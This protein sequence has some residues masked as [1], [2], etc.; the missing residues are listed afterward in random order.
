[1][2]AVTVHIEKAA[3]GGLPSVAVPV[4]QADV[5]KQLGN[6]VFISSI[7]PKT[8]EAGQVI[9]MAKVRI[10][11]DHP[12]F[13]EHVRDHLPGL[14]IIEAGR[15]V[16]LAIPHLFYDVGYD[17]GF[18]LEACDMRFSGFINLSDD[19]FIECR[20]F[21]P[22]YRRGKL[23]SLSFDGI[24]LQNGQACVH[25]QSHIKRIHRKLLAR[26]ER[27]SG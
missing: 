24:F 27:H 5:H 2:S 7:T 3:K 1:V 25:Y 8:D 12:Y 10:I 19:L 23:Q 14:Y 9:Y 26:Y 20:I 16:G 13:F 17:Y 6:N 21:N 18:V 15:Q 11:P 22:V 4:R